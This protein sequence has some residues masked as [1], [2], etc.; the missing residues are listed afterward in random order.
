MEVMHMGLS[1]IKMVISTLM[2]VVGH[3]LAFKA[4]ALT[5]ISVLIQIAQFV[6]MLKRDKEQ[7]HSP[8]AYIHSKIIE[9]P[10]HHSPQQPEPYGGSG[11][12]PN[13]DYAAPYNVRRRR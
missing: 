11:K 6:M 7:H 13:V 12:V 1:Y 5:L 2:S 4:V 3:V 9:S 8:P 10:Y